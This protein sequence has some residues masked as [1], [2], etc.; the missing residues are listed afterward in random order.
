M[1]T[2]RNA[3]AS[4]AHPLR[5]HVYR[6]FARLAAE[7][8][9]AGL[10]VSLALALAIFIVSTQAQAA[11]T[12]AVPGQG[13][14]MLKSASGDAPVAAPLLFTDVDIAVS[15]MTARA[16]V[17][18][19]FA[20]PT[21]VWQEGVYVFPLPE[22]AAVDHLEMMIGQRRIEGQVRERG[23]ARATY[24]QAKTDGR[25]ATLVEQERPNV[26]TTNVAHIG[27][28]EEITV[29]IE[30][31]ETLRYDAGVFRLRFPMVVA[32]RYVPGAFAVDGEPGTGWGMN[33]DQVP[34]AERITPPVVHPADGF[35]NP[36]TINIELNPGFA[37]SRIDSPYHRID[38]SEAADHRYAIRLSNGSVPANRDFELVWAPD[39]AAV[40]GAAVFTERIDGKTYALAMIVPPAPV[41]G[42][43]APR[44]PREAVFIV[45]TSGS[46][47][48]T[49]ITQA[50]QALQ[51]AL[52]RLQPGDRFNVIEFN[53][54]TKALFAAPMPVD[55]ATLVKAKTFVSG[56][57]A[58]GGTEMKPAL[59]A[60][61][62]RDPAPDF[63]RQVVF[64]TDGAVGNE[65]ELVALI[66]AR[67][68]DRRLFTIGI[69]SAPNS[70]FL[71]KAA[72][73]GRG[74]FTYIGDVREV[75]EKMGA[76]FTKLESPVLTDIAISWPGKAEVWP[77]EPGDL[78]AGE[79]IVVVAQTDALE[80]DVAI[81]GR[82]AGAPWSA[83]VPLSASAGEPG[84]GVLW[85]RAK[86]E[87][88]TDALKGGESEAEVRKSIIEIALAHHLVSKYT[89]LVAV[90]VTP[91]VPPGTTST[92]TAL[93]VNLPEG[94]SYEAI[95]GG[96]QTATPAALHLLSGLIALLL[97]VIAWSSGDRRL[98]RYAKG[99]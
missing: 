56:L 39:V 85:A 46:M 82:R 77:H 90:D 96:A 67:L 32:P 8:L 54:A 68:A 4:A 59:E 69:G 10:V 48:G 95:F 33:T 53:S 26:F 2:G 3:H 45:D 60:A 63:V 92:T 36:V 97:A 58:R 73:Y 74:T 78:Y 98:P 81:T 70:F 12:G 51:M 76:L 7:A 24:E 80:G 19:R 55:S 17:T 79:P 75:A 93:P 1:N 89:S 11:D 91:T 14:L 15:G 21:A 18:Q 25:K 57:R 34:D 27:P 9:A 84:I 35:V 50:K 13:T 43:G 5:G 37:L 87:A 86:I 20:N 44:S 23:E 88:L 99:D 64:L 62:T 22:K 42:R 83:R 41:A 16:T 30:Y 28:G 65:G 40:P 66:R 71:T 49:S 38:V 94:A 29:T 72:Q 6:D 47:E 52:D 31:Q 61:L